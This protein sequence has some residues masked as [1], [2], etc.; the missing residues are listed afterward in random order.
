MRNSQGHRLTEA[1]DS[2]LLYALSE[3]IKPI[4]C[5]VIEEYRNG[6]TLHF[7]S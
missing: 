7:L 2:S 6:S 5:N 4:L 1:F 3:G